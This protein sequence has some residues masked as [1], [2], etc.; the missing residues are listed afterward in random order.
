[1]HDKVFSHHDAHKL[2]DPERLAWLPP[3]D[4]IDALGLAAGMTVADIGAGTGYFAFPLAR[5]V[6]AAGKVWAIDLQP[7]MLD[8]LRAKLLKDAAPNV[9]LVLGDATAT[10]LG[11]RCADVVLMANLFHELPDVPAALRES[12]RILRAKGR[13]AIVDWRPDVERPP[14]PPIEH[15]VA[16][17]RVAEE[18]SA[19][20]WSVAHRANV[21]RYSYLV[22]AT[23]A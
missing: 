20:G 11:S 15:R 5:A 21:G 1:M 23:R 18:L 16:L 2:D 6:G 3:A 13:L 4:V 8:K 12:A 22:V 19:N 9:E 7:E 10:S 14:G 17:A